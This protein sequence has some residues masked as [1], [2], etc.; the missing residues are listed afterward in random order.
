MM[1]KKA[2][3]IKN[4]NELSL[5]EKLRKILT[6]HGDDGTSG[7]LLSEDKINEIIQLIEEVKKTVKKGGEKI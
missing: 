7:Y 3:K 2:S 6:F 1:G 5:E 4:W